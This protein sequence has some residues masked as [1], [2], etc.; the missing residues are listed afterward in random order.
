MKARLA[1]SLLF[2]LL[3]CLPLSAWAEPILKGTPNELTAHLLQSH[4]IISIGGTSE[5]EASADRAIISLVVKT[6]ESRFRTALEKNRRIRETMQEKLVQK[7]VAAKD[8]QFS[9]FSNTPSYGFFS[10]K[11]SSYEVSN[12]VKITIGKEEL[13]SEIASMVDGQNEVYFVGSSIEHSQEEQSKQEALEKAVQNALQKRDMYQ[14]QLGVKLKAVK[15][16]ELHVGPMPVVMPMRREAM[17]KVYS[18]AAVSTAE[19]QSHFGEIKY[20]AAVEV[21]FIVQ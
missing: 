11:P 6:S 5:V 7:G 2:F 12:E 3:F 18:S 19:T 16:T 9:R 8:I 15:V 14:K 10:D 17:D 21:E 4:Q 1:W 13:L 20:Q